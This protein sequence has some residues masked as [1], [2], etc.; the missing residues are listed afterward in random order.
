MLSNTKID[1]LVYRLGQNTEATENVV[2]EYSLNPN[3]DI[4]LKFFFLNLKIYE[5]A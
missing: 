4:V 5:R 3:C 1:W 2:A